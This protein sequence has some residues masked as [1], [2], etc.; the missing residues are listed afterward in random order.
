M[1]D[2]LDS[3]PNDISVKTKIWGP[4]AWFF[5]H[6]LVMAYPKKLNENNERHKKIKNSMYLFLSNLGN[7]LPCPICGESY[8]EYI[9]EDRYSIKKALNGR[10]ELM[11]W[12]YI[13]H[14]RVNDKLG[15]PL[16]DRLSFN[17]MINK[18]TKFIAKNGCKATTKQERIKK[19]E[20]G[21]TDDDFKDYKCLINIQENIL[22]N[23]TENIKENRTENIKENIKE[24]RKENFSGNKNNFGSKF[25]LLIIF[26]LLIIIIYLILKFK[27]K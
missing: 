3:L 25:Q 11:Y 18:Y 9:Q 15:V 26:V 8:N 22:K 21:C 2:S 10:K 4:T 12:S 14:E 7:V 16:C 17:E 24:N 19:R 5:L 23:R 20:I 6:N 13:I 1:S 27:Y